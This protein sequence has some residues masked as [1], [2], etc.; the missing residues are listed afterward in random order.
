MSE[1]TI[2]KPYIV[3]EGL[4]QAAKA[5]MI[6]N[7][8]LLITGAPGT[9]KTQFAEHLAATEGLGEPLRFDVK[10]TSHAKDLL[11][12][13]DSL[14]RFQAV[15]LKIRQ[16]SLLSYVHFNAL[17]RAFLF[18][19]GRRRA[20]ALLRK[21]DVVSPDD[22]D[23][24]EHRIFAE[25]GEPRRS[26]VLIDEIDKAPRDFPND[27]LNELDPKRRYFS[28][29]E[30]DGVQIDADK[31]AFA[32]IVVI[33]SNEE[34]NLPAAFLRRCVFFHI[35]TPT[36]ER[37]IDILKAHG[38]P[39]GEFL[40]SAYA[41]YMAVVELGRDRKTP[42]TDELIEWLRYLREVGANPSVPLDAPENRG[43]VPGT[44]G[45]LVKGDDY[46]V[47]AED[48]ARTNFG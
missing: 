48:L 24:I 14:G 21:F 10:S 8:P 43:L 28:V 5:A 33:T 6:L 35:D 47:E 30:L 1:K 7:R 20:E 12:Q 25:L 45:V 38:T 42:G 9:G 19:L 27:L 37:M 23:P 36:G 34:R 4:A 44:M 18:S 13:F 46:L 11:Y 22:G 41:F 17:G 39:A 2:A 3:P 26:V 31:G 40:T 16:R 15:H 29:P 32:P